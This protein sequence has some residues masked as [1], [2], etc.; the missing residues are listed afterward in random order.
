LWTRA[1]WKLADLFLDG[2]FERSLYTLH[3]S[4]SHGYIHAPCSEVACLVISL[5]VV[6]TRWLEQ[7]YWQTGVRS[8]C[9]FIPSLV[10]LVFPWKVMTFRSFVSDPILCLSAVTESEMIYVQTQ[11]SNEVCLR[12]KVI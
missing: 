8:C 11:T 3:P 5:A 9:S 7:G 1:Y 6:S 2:T 4:A 12:R 10:A